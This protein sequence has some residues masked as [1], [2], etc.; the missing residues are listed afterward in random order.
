MDASMDAAA[1][2]SA[3]VEAC[4]R[5]RARRRTWDRNRAARAEAQMTKATLTALFGLSCVDAA[6]SV[7][8][9]LSTFKRMCR[10]LG[11]A[12]WPC[13]RRTVL[14]CREEVALGFFA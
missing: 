9:G 6:A 4:V 2:D 11:I 3:R 8:V 14:A 7:G 13:S 5:V 1:A 10:R 12:R